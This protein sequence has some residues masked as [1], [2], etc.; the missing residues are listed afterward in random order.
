MNRRVF[1]FPQW[2]QPSKKSDTCQGR[3][4]GT[5]QESS[6]LATAI[7]VRVMKVFTYFTAAKLSYG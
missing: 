3:L 1:F 4:S 2:A 6:R 7:L 5:A